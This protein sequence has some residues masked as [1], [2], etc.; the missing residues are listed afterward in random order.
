[1][2]KFKHKKSYNRRISFFAIFSLLS[3]FTTFGQNQ[4]YL[5][6]G[7]VTS[8]QGNVSYATLGILESNLGTITDEIGYFELNIPKSL[9]DSKLTVSCIGYET[10]VLKIADLTQLEKLNILLNEKIEYLNEVVV[11]AGRARRRIKE[12][13]NLKAHDLYLLI[14]GEDRGSEIA[15]LIIPKTEFEIESAFLNIQNNSGRS[16]TL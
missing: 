15:T 5:L 1:M 8:N 14:K 13:G 11:I 12:L 9:W 16:F 7:Y 10:K 6:K 2:K 4:E 3:L